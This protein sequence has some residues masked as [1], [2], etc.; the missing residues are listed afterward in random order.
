MPPMKR[1]V[2]AIIQARMGSS[3]LP[4]KV[5]KPLCGKAIL[6][7]ILQRI[8]CVEAVD[9]TAVATTRNPIDKPI[10]E[11]AQSQGVSCFRGSEEDVL[12]RF[13]QSARTFDAK[14]DDV[15]IRLTGDNPFVDPKICSELLSFFLDSSFRYVTT[16]G[17]P[18][19]VGTEIF[20]FSALEEAHTQASKA[21]EREHVTPFL[22]RRGQ[23]Y[24]IMESSVDNSK[25]RLTVDSPEDYQ[26]A[27]QIYDS[28]YP[29]NREF[30]LAE[31]LAYLKAN[32]AV[33]AINQGVHQKQLGE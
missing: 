17:Y 10:A 28:L 30:G 2:L 12:D 4:G 3:R 6:Y 25:V 22:Y 14:S 29:V 15:I 8:A 13:F 7:H 31:I 5:L 16:R 1:R 24:G 21:Y 23:R 19:G 9:E 32:P 18:L 33:A 11:F 27:R 20:T 26:V